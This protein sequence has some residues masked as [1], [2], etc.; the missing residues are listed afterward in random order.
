MQTLLNPYS[1]LYQGIEDTLYYYIV[2][3]NTGV[4]AYVFSEYNT[5]FANKEKKVVGKCFYLHVPSLDN[6]IC[7]NFKTKIICGKNF[8]NLGYK[9]NGND[10]IVNPDTDIKNFTSQY[11]PCSQLSFD[12]IFAR[13]YSCFN[14]DIVV[15]VSEPKVALKQL[16]AKNTKIHS[17]IDEIINSFEV[18]VND[19]GITGSTA[20]S[21]DISSDYDIIFY[22]NINKLNE[23]KCKI[24]YFRHKRGIVNEY[25]MN[26]PCRYYDSN[27][28]LICCFFVCTDYNYQPLKSAKIV[29]NTYLFDITIKDASLSTLKAPVLEVHDGCIT[30]LIIFNSGFKGV[31]KSGDRIKG[32]GKIIKYHDNGREHYSILSL[33]P[34]REIQNYNSFFCR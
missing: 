19:L 24:D 13:N 23:I 32:Y 30:S 10:F 20:L 11:L 15:G 18:D 2:D 29:E 28:N 14:E 6:R 4:E 33:N 1:N 31:L 8:L 5:F 16:Y 12:N 21:G 3:K 27:S 9:R 22:S 17:I 7:Q 25:K 34:Y 26:W